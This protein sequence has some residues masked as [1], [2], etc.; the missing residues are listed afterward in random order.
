[1]V[2]FLVVHADGPCPCLF[3][4]RV[5][6]HQVLPVESG[7]RHAIPAFF[8]TRP[9]AAATKASDVVRDDN[10]IADALW[11]LALWPQTEGDVR[12]FMQLWHELLS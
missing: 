11:R 10:T 9:V 12:T 4:M 8:V 6:V 2:R 1:M 5:H 3:N 7:V